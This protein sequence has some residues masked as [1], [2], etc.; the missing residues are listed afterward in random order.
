MTALRHALLLLVLL[1]LAACK[2]DAPAPV[3]AGEAAPAEQA[4]TQA[5]SAEDP[6]RAAQAEAAV[7]AAAEAAAKAPP[8]VEGTDYVTIANGQPFDTAP[9]RIEVVEFFGYVCPFCAAVQPQVAAMKAKL[10]PDV[11]FVY[12]PAAF[13]AMWDNY[14][15]AFYAA[16]AMGLLD[17]T[18]DAMFR[19]IHI[20]QTLKGERGMD[21]PEDIA[22]FYANY[23]ANPGQFLNSMQSFAVAT[24]MNRARQYMT[25][26][27]ANGDQMGTPAFVVAGKYRVKGK[28]VDDMFR[29]INQLIVA[30]RTKLGAATP[31]APAPAAAEAP[32][33]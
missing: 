28:S 26:A 21:K 22:G 12:V 8:P 5:A 3:A 14:A 1:P 20:D 33:G 13:G 23:G 19:A 29:I 6:Q 11:H 15:K 32:Q 25:E 9:G 18:H 16:E 30:E 17:K 2:N 10:P 24:K 4:T 31:A 7:Q 27:F